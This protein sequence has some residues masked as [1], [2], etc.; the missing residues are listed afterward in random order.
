[1]E[2]VQQLPATCDEQ[3]D[4]CA[5]NACKDVQQGIYAE[6]RKLTTWLLDRWDIGPIRYDTCFL[7]HYHGADQ[8]V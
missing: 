3:A 5:L 7:L 6:L 4:H 1:M 2:F 8:A